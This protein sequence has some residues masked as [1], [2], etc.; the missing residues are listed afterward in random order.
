MHEAFYTPVWTLHWC[1][2]FLPSALLC[3]QSSGENTSYRSY[4]SHQNVHIWAGGH[5]M[6][7]CDGAEPEWL[8]YCELLPSISWV[9]SKVLL[10]GPKKIDVS[11]FMPCD[12]NLP[13]FEVK[14]CLIFHCCPVPLTR[15]WDDWGGI[16]GSLPLSCFLHFSLPMS[17]NKAHEWE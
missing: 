13:I 15:M 12:T 5:C 6:C 2:S 16:F 10:E 9:I 11:E 1:P 4:S 3:F 7:F 8:I 17:I 14:R